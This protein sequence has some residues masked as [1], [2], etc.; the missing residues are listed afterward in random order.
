MNI[1]VMKSSYFHADLVD[2]GLYPLK[3]NNYPN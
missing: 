3:Y 1:Y 2:I